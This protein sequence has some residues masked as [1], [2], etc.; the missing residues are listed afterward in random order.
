M[1][2]PKTVYGL[3]VPYDKSV[4]ELIALTKDKPP[5]CWNAYT[6]LAYKTGDEA[7]HALKEMLANPDWT[8]IRSTI[9]AIGNNVK[10]TRLSDQLISFL[11][12][13]NKFIVTAAIKA[14]S[15]LRS[16]KAHD[17]IRALINFE[18][19]EIRQAA[20]EG[21]SN[22]WLASDFEF[23]LDID[24]GTNNVT[25]R[26]NIGFVLAEHVDQ[27]NWRIFF[28]NYSKDSVTRHRE[29]SLVFAHQFSNDKTLIEPFLKDQDGHIRKKAQ[30]CMVTTTSL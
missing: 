19:V 11:D 9:E 26:K 23:L 20:I 4:E 15:K 12:N 2:R 27:T 14:L 28:D 24:K 21:L 3:E 13:T 10:G 18:N 22:I 16:T 1:T 29:W 6:A 5:V 8:H 30:K 17:K 25:I 7:I